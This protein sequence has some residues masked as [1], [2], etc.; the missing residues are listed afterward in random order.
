MVL[1]CISGYLFYCNTFIFQPQL[2]LTVFADDEQ[3]SYI[4]GIP[5]FGLS[6]NFI[7]HVWNSNNYLPDLEDEL[8][9]WQTFATV[10]RVV[11]PPAPGELC[12][13]GEPF[14]GGR[15]PIVRYEA[16]IGAS[17]NEVDVSP[18]TEVRLH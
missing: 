10:I 17:P 4:C 12:R 8:D 14:R 3:L 2:C 18:F 13:Y 7:I 6:T 15:I 5:E 9:S 1:T 11:F 16:G